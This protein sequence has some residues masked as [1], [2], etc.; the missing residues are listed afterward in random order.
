MSLGRQ[1]AVLERQLEPLPD[2]EQRLGQCIDQCIL[3]VGRGGDAQPLRPPRHGRIVDR[4][5][6]D[7]VIGEQEIA[8]P[9]FRIA[10]LRDMAIQ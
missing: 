6:V 10:G 7:A 1:R 8:R 3:V 2:V 4:L 5:N 9:L